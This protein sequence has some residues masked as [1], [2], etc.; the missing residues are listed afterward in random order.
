MVLPHFPCLMSHSNDDEHFKFLKCDLQ[1]LGK[2]KNAATAQQ[3]GVG[4][5]REG[6]PRQRTINYR[7]LSNIV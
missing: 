4:T 7:N 6:K 1:K 5:T 2:G 3:S